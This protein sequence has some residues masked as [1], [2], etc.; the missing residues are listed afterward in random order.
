MEGEGDEGSSSSK[1]LPRATA[2]PSS[3]MHQSKF[4]QEE[5]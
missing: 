4:G 2:A 3:A 1:Q 5:I